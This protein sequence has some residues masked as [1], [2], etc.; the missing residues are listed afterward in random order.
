M[1][2]LSTILDKCN[3]SKYRN[4]FI[5]YLT[6]LDFNEFE[7]L[8]NKYSELII[9]T[10]Y[11]Y[12]NSKRF[13]KNWLKKKL[14]D[15]KLKRLYLLFLQSNMY[16]VILSGE[17]LKNRN[18]KRRVILKNIEES[19]ELMRNLNNNRFL[20]LSITPTY[21]DLIKLYILMMDN[22]YT[23]DRLDNLIKELILIDE[24]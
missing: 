3:R 6:S 20:E 9:R 1:V 13:S 12:R 17:N 14:L 24:T 4:E 16:Y 5:K 21:E 22:I 18:E 15:I 8:Y 11:K 10:G 19:K 7:Y 2:K 23:K